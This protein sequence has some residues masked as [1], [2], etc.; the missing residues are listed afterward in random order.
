M[1]SAGQYKH[2]PADNDIN[3]ED[4]LLKRHTRYAL[5]AVHGGIFSMWTLDESIKGILWK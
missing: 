3:N 1:N 2:W 5:V 4:V